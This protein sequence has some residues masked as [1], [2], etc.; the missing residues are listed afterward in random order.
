[1]PKPAVAAY[2]ARNAGSVRR[3]AL[4]SQIAMATGAQSAL[5]FARNASPQNPPASVAAR[6]S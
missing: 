6:G 2:D 5:S 1:M 4:N 3:A